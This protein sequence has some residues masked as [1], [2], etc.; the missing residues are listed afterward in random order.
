MKPNIKAI[1]T[2]ALVCTVSHAQ[3]EHPQPASSEKP[4]TPYPGLGTW[5]HP[6]TTQ[7]PEAQKY[8]DQGL[9]LLYGFNRYEARRSFQKA[10]ELDRSAVRHG[11]A[12]QCRSVH[13][14]TWTWT[15]T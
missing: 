4:V 14:S 1:A 5:T 2:I 9:T 6:I 8:F 13:T 7:N 3:H 15:R 10:L 11:G 12:L